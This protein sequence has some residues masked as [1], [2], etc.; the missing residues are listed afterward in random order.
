MRIP[1]H[2]PPSAHDEG[3]SSADLKLAIPSLHCLDTLDPLDDS[4]FLVGIP[5]SWENIIAT[6]TG[7]RIGISYPVLRVP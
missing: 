1:T 4:I 3:P 7:L 2:D 6:A 5:S